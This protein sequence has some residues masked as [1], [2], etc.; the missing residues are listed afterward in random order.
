MVYKFNMNAL[1]NI[2]S[3]RVK[4]EVFRLLFGLS[5]GELHLREIA[6]RA[7]LS[8]GTVQQELA[9]LV[10]AGLV[11]T[12]RDGN[13]LYHRANRNHPLYPEIHNMVLKT[14]GLAEVLQ[15]ALHHSSIQMAFVFGSVARNEAGASSDIDLMIVGQLGLRLVT[16]M[17][18]GLTGTLGRE[19]NPHVMSPDEFKRRKKSKDHFL[20]SVLESPKIF[21]VGGERELEAMV[22]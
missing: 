18:S 19:I 7:G 22:R 9:G 13:R 21:I 20:S 6:R 12:R 15:K 10:L 11:S 8:I 17:L 5:D 2:L 3:S 1:Q 14:S 4:A 16:N